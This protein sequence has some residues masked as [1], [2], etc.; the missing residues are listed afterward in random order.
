[1][2]GSARLAVASHASA[3]AAAAAAAAAAGGP[4]IWTGMLAFLGPLLVFAV[5]ARGDPFARAHAVAALRFNLS[6]AVYLGLIAAIAQLVPGSA[7]TVQLVPFLMFVTML[8]AFNWLVFIGIGVHAGRDGPAVHVPDVP[9][10]ARPPPTHPRKT[11]LMPKIAFVGAGSTVF[12]RNLIG[13]VVRFPA[14]A[15]ATTFSL[16]DIDRGRLETSEL[17]ARRLVEA[18][19]AG[20]TVETTLDRRAALEGADYVVT[21]FQVGGLRPSTVVD[22]E[23]PKRYG[24]RQTIADTLGVGGI[25]RG[26]RHDPGAAG[27]V[28]RHG[29]GLP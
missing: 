14:L 29:G 16:M 9:A 25:M 15:D 2:S 20:A 17:V 24:L 3:V 11:C 23:I 7:Y 1:M 19:G 28:P 8:L 5:A 6:V 13:D 22:F 27:R 4:A 10:L 18:A 21:S 12:T 26:L